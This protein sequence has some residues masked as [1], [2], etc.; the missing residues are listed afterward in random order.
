MIRQH[1]RSLQTFAVLALAACASAGPGE[2]LPGPTP[3]AA[4]QPAATW[5]AGTRQHIDL[6]L[7]GFALLSPDTG[8]VPLFKRGYASRIAEIKGR[9]NVRTSLDVNRDRLSTHLAANRGLVNAQFR[10]ITDTIR[11]DTRLFTRGRARR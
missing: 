11:L 9:G 1:T 2:P 5:P 8:R 10:L 3:A 4:G 7:H 6:W